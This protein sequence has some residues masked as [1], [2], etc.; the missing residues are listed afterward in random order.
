MYPRRGS[1]ITLVAILFLCSSCTRWIVRGPQAAYQIVSHSGLVASNSPML[2]E[3]HHSRNL[4]EGQ[5]SFEYSVVVQNKTSDEEQTLKL[6]LANFVVNGEET[7]VVCHD[8]KK[9]KNVVLVK[10][11]QTQVKCQVDLKASVKNQLLNKDSQGVLKIPYGI[12]Q[13]DAFQTLDFKHSLR[14]EDFE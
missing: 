3:H 13:T 1:L 11:A 14:I 2:F 9:S 12:A 4:Q 10:G 6:A 7:S 5:Y 8:L